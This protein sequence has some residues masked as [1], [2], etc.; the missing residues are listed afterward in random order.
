MAGN[1]CVP[2]EAAV[3]GDAGA[4]DGAGRDAGLDA[5]RV[6][7]HVRCSGIGTVPRSARA[8]RPRPL[9]I[10][11]ASVPYRPRRVQWARHTRPIGVPCGAELVV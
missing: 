9:D 5:S 6:D 11:P 7:A 10:T 4:N 8:Q 3:M 2:S 1:H